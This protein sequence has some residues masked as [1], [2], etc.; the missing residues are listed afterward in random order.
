MPLDH[1]GRAELQCADEGHHGEDGEGAL[2]FRLTE[3]NAA[4]HAEGQDQD[5]RRA[6]QHQVHREDAR[7]QRRVHP[8]RADDVARQAAGAQR[9][10]QARDGG[11]EAE[12][13]GLVGGE[14]ARQGQRGTE[15]CQEQAALAE[16]HPGQAPALRERGRRRRFRPL[17][18]FCHGILRTRQGGGGAG[19]GQGAIGQNGLTVPGRPWQLANRRTRPTPVSRGQAGLPSSSGAA[20]RPE[21]FGFLPGKSCLSLYGVSR[22]GARR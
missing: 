8:L 15:L 4:E 22:I 5:R 3:E 7:Q 13:A 12:D 16:S 2:D 19:C 9:R 10:Q 21:T 11:R 20:E 6:R 18:E 17:S 14:Q 1:G